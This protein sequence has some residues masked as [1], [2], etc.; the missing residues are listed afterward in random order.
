MGDEMSQQA[1]NPKHAIGRT[2]QSYRCVP[3]VAFAALGTVMQG[4][5]D[6]YGPFN[7]GEAGVTATVYY[8]AALRHLIAWFT[9]QD[10]DP[11]SGQPHLA[12][13]MACCAILLDSTALGNLEDDRPS[14]STFPVI[15]KGP[16]DERDG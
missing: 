5:A 4:G 12:H 13:V 11:E 9:G 7:W 15:A 16:A 2:K 1:N 6:K 8:D 3:P 14:G 10:L